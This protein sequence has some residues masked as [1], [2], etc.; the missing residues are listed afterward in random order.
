[1]WCVNY[2]KIH[3]EEDTIKTTRIQK[4]EF[5][6]WK[7]PRHVSRRTCTDK[8]LASLSTHYSSTHSF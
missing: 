5:D 6:L 8:L 4:F 7:H 3:E 2:N 1:M